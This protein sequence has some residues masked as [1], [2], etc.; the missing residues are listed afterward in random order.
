[1]TVN[2]ETNLTEEKRNKKKL[3]SRSHMDEVSVCTKRKSG[4]NQNRGEW[5]ARATQR[6]CPT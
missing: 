6:H 5:S 1:M 2:A 3:N 4:A